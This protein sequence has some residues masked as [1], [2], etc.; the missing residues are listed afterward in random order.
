[1]RRDYHNKTGEKLPGVTTIIDAVLAKPALVG[2]AYKRGLD[3][4]ELYESRDKAAS[5]GTLA[6]LMVERHLNKL[7]ELKLSELTRDNAPDDIKKLM[8][9]SQAIID[10]A[11]GCYLAFLQW[12]D[13][14]KFVMRV[15]E[16]PLVSEKYQ[17]AG[18]IDIAAVL[19]QLCIVDIKTGNGIYTS[20]KIQVAAYGLLYDENAT[21]I[22]IQGYH[23]VRLSEFGGFDHK[24]C[25][26]L[27]DEQE[28]FLNALRIY[29]ILKKTG[30]KL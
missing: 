11:E 3:G 7:P 13:T 6:H 8:P 4:K 30:Q 18:T 25:P 16:I 1:M 28:I 23:I 21:D 14:H 20:M 26:S 29:H 2:W 5:A 24:Y 15:A 12:E 22:R 10:K 9:L 27:K 17:F 19:G